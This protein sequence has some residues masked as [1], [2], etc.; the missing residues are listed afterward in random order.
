[1]LAYFNIGNLYFHQREFETSLSFY[2]KCLEINRNDE[3][4]LLNRGIVRAILEDYT[5]ALAD[6]N[7]VLV[8]NAENPH[9]YFNRAQIYQSMAAY[10]LAEADYRKVLQLIPDDSITKLRI[11][12][13][14][15]HQSRISEAMEWFANVEDKELK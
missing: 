15:S 5:G 12:H 8:I 13:T 2:D 1:M 11:G 4:S 6:V 9:A 14:I 3:F 7:D 10:D